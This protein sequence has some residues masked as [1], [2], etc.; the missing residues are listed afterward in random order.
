M[1]GRTGKLSLNFE[2]FQ[3]YFREVRGKYLTG[4]YTEIT[5]RTPFENFIK[6]LS[7]DFVLIQEPKRTEIGAPD[8]KA[9]RKTVKIGYIETKDLNKNLDEELKSDQVKKYR[10][11]IDNIVLTNY[12]RVMLLRAGQKPFD[13]N[14]FNLSDLDNPKF[15]ISDEKVKEFWRLLE[16]FF[17]YN[18]PT[19]KSALELSLELSKKAKLLKELAKEQLEEDLVKIKNGEATSSVNDFYEGTKE[20]IKDINVDDCADA[21]AQTIT[22]GLFLA[23][24]KSPDVLDRD[25]AASHIPR[26]I[27]II[28][29]IFLN[30]SGDS[31]P[32]NLSWIIDEIID[33]LNAS[34][35]K[36]ILSEIDVRGKTDKDPFI[37]FYEDFLS[38]YD[39]E[40]RKQLGVYYTP[41]LV[42]NFI[43]NS[44][45]SI[46]KSDFNKP[47]GFADDDVT[48]LDPAVGTGTFLWLIY[49]LTMVELWRR[50]GFLLRRKTSPPDNIGQCSFITRI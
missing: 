31:V 30:I 41:R 44:I 35:I 33:V 34:S 2:R 8:F 9:F 28:K 13:F 47:N 21:Y 50:K 7:D 12:N 11:S 48:V 36:D 24:T 25:T 27:G 39:P 19:I 23:K 22:Y 26:S 17:S 38:S 45:H 5:L 6:G 32:R 29:R 40:K 49:N 46:L 37:S 20:L 4:D 16:T 10:E 3:E 18:L 15:V 14:L 42:V 1:A 43:A